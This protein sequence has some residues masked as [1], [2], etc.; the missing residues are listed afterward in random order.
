MMSHLTST[1]YIIGYDIT[2]KTPWV[3]TLSITGCFIGYDITMKM[4]R[5]QFYLLFH[6]LELYHEKAMS[7]QYKWRRQ[8]L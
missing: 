2:M 5:V 8:F 6:R 7:S 1:G 4:Q 3:P